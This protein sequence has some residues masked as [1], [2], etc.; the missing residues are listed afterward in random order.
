MEAPPGRRSG[1]PCTPPEAEAR[2]GRCTVSVD[3][4]A[5]WR[6]PD[7]DQLYLEL[8]LTFDRPWERGAPPLPDA[9]GG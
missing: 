8:R 2:L 4:A 6:E 5:L 9:G 1:L 7:G 3:R